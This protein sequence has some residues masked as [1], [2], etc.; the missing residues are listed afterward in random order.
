M[1]GL[2]RT[3][4]AQLAARAAERSGFTL[5]EVLIVL[6]II[7][8]GILPLAVVQIRARQEVSAA[9]RYTQAAT[10][11]QRQLEWTKG[12]GLQQAAADSGQDGALSWRTDVQLVEAGLGRVSVTV[13]YPRGASP[14]TLRMVSLLSER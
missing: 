12:L 5:V 7:T 10:L 2:Q 3:L 9:D 1:K 8:I 13:V 6:L 11:A 4:R 14:D